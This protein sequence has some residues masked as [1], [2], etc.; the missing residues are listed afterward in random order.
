[1]Y[2]TGRD[3]I[4]VYGQTNTPN[5]YT[6]NSRLQRF[7]LVVFLAHTFFTAVTITHSLSAASAGGDDPSGTV[8]VHSDGVSFYNLN[9][10][11]ITSSYRRLPEC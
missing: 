4:K 7:C 6:G 10:G 11:E 9:I 1:V 3:N 2:I 5:S 8:R